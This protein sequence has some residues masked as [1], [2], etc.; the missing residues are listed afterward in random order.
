[1]PS[2]YT[3]STQPWYLMGLEYIDDLLTLKPGGW[4]EIGSS[5]YATMQKDIDISPIYMQ[6]AM[7]GFQLLYIVKGKYWITII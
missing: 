7:L 4:K 6:W 3:E 1:M 5:D 2:E